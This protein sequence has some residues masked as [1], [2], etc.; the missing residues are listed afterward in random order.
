MAQIQEQREL[1]PEQLARIQK[2]RE[3]QRK[4][5]LMKSTANPIVWVENFDDEDWQQLLRVDS[6]EGCEDGKTFL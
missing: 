5:L 2:Q 1:I 6:W 3:L 4:R